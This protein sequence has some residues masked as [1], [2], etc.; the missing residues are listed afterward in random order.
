MGRGDRDQWVTLASKF[1][2]SLDTETDA[3]ALRDGFTPDAYNQDIDNPGRLAVGSVPT[4]TARVAKTFSVGGNTYNW[5]L[6]RLWRA[7]G[8]DLFYGGR[9][10]QDVFLRRGLGALSFDE[11]AESIVTFMPFAAGMF[12]CK[13]TGGYA[14]DTRFWQHGDIEQQM[15]TSNANYANELNG[16]VYVSNANGVYAWNGGKVVEVTAPVRSSLSNFASIDLLCDYR[17]QRIIGTD[18]FVWDTQRKALYRF[19][20]TG[21]RWTSP[22]RMKPDK[23]PFTVKDLEF[24]YEFTDTENASL[25]Y[26]VRYEKDD[27]SDGTDLTLPYVDEKLVASRFDIEN[28]FQ[29]SKFQMRI[30]AMSS[31]IRIHEINML[32]DLGADKGSWRE[33]T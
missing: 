29:A 1:P 20:S 6:R 14:V 2:A 8:A 30:T 26:Q 9:E 13:S 22:R 7:V 32:A 15:G 11:D 18:K 21:F 12:V 10:Y 24:V 33:T 23:A 16:V 28:R 5:Y 19:E 17:R 27:W 25:T 3:T 31:N 4:G